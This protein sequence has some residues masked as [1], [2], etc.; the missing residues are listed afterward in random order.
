MCFAP[1][2]SE[3]APWRHRLKVRADETIRFVGVWT[4]ARLG[5]DVNR[6]RDR[7]ERRRR[8]RKLWNAPPFTAW[9]VLLG[10]VGV[11]SSCMRGTLL[12]LWLR[13]LLCGHGSV[14]IGNMREAC[15]AHYPPQK[16]S[17]ALAFGKA[18]A[19][20]ELSWYGCSHPTAMLSTAW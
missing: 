16:G 9:V 17:G 14:V 10:A 11:A 20:K 6:Y 7:E 4:L 8:C 19:P 12:R 18:R 15:A 5:V 1:R 2:W 13:L 3:T